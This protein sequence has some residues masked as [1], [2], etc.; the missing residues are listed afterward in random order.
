MSSITHAANPT[1]ITKV[2]TSGARKVMRDIRN[3]FSYEQVQNLIRDATSNTNDPPTPAQ[4]SKIS[5]TLLY[6]ENY[7]KMF[8]MLW[9]RLCHLEYKRHVVK[10]LL[11]LDYL[12]R[13]KPP[14]LAVQLRLIVDVRERWNEIWRLAKLRT[15]SSSDTIRQIQRVAERL[16]DWIMRY[17]QGEYRL[18]ETVEESEFIQINEEE[19][20][21]GARKK[22]KKKKIKKKK[23]SKSKEPSPQQSEEEGEEEGEDDDNDEE[24]EGESE[25]DDSE[26]NN[27]YSQ[28]KVQAPNSR[29]NNH[30]NNHNNNNNNN[31]R[32]AKLPVSPFG[33]D[34]FDFDKN[35]N[36]EFQPAVEPQS[37]HNH[38]MDFD[39]N[40]HNPHNEQNLPNG[41]NCSR[42]TYINSW[43]RQDC[44][45]CAT[46]RDQNNQKNNNQHQQLSVPVP[47]HQNY[48]Q[49]NV[50]NY[51][52][53]PNDF[54]NKQGNND[55]P[56][57]NITNTAATTATS[58]TNHNNRFELVA[59]SGWD[60]A[61]CSFHN[62]STATHCLICE[63]DRNEHPDRN[64][65]IEG[66]TTNTNEGEG[67]GVEGKEGI[68]NNNNNN[69]NLVSNAGNPFAVSTPSPQASADIQVGLGS[70]SK[71]NTGLGKL[72]RGAIPG[73]WACSW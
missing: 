64:A 54:N 68:N 73:A 13:L 58:T 48:Y 26:R 56:F 14:S 55:D 62:K 34:F 24:Q 36:L 7:D 28:L 43:D 31:N 32:H 12:I 33:F 30:H 18:E 22:K 46:P 5:F 38:S 57:N 42:C 70:H 63:H 4:L 59:D 6:H 65:H 11:V 17:E 15:E 45:I 20:E 50:Y 47:S 23:K 10:A 71:L 66:N 3:K 69:S 61:Y 39:D 40:N 53:N 27:S 67:E 60:C 37:Q 44:E 49:M 2:A 52:G 72:E 16:C 9:K 21:N 35:I 1:T 19:N 8:A 51:Y 41:W 25:D 29:D